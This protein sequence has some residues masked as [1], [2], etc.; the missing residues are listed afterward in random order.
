MSNKSAQ[1]YFILIPKKMSGSVCRTENITTNTISTTSIKYTLYLFSNA[2]IQYPP[3]HFPPGDALQTFLGCLQAAILPA[4]ICA[5]GMWCVLV[6]L[7][8]RW[9]SG[10]DWCLG[11]NHI[12]AVWIVSLPSHQCF[13]PGVITPPV[14]T[15]L[16]SNGEHRLK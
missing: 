12:C 7:H 2:G 15:P 13:F 4:G 1:I 6:L 3:F 8:R 9:H 11:E 5:S 10:L 14:N 16:S